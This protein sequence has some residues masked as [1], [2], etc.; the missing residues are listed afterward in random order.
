MIAATAKVITLPGYGYEDDDEFKGYANAMLKAA[1]AMMAAAKKGEFENFQK[2][3]SQISQA[4]TQ[5][6]S[7]YRN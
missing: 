4:C 3:R 5:C 6:H 2:A 1:Q 7:S